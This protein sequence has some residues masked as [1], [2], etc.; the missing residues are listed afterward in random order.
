MILAENRN[1]LGGR[2]VEILGTDISREQ[3]DRAQEGLYTQFEVQRGLPMQHLVK[4]FRKDG[5]QW[6]VHDTLRAM[7]IFR[8]WNLLAD[9]RP[10]GQFDVIFCRNVLIYFDLCGHSASST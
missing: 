6:R 5:P 3:L 4:Y 8:E 2:E 10:L 7:T 1:V 9:P